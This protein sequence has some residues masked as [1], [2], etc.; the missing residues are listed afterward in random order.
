MTRQGCRTGWPCAGRCSR[1]RGIVG[2]AT[3]AE[4]PLQVVAW[5][6]RGVS[7]NAVLLGESSPLPLA[8][9]PQCRSALS[10][11]LPPVAHAHV[12]TSGVAVVGLLLA[13]VACDVK[14]ALWGRRRVGR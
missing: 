12:L 13:V 11:V 1:C 7:L 4:G 6:R 3:C 8:T 2:A 5:L 10:W 14:V 9:L